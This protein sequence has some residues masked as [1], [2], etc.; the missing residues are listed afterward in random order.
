MGSSISFI[1]LG[2]ILF[3][4]W[5]IFRRLTFIKLKDSNKLEPLWK[6]NKINKEFSEEEKINYAGQCIRNVGVYLL[7]YLISQLG[8]T[9]GLL[10]SGSGFTVLCYALYGIFS[11]IL[12]V[13]IVS[14]IYNAGNLL[15]NYKV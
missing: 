8:V 5:L 6:R 14:E 3:V 1:F 9:I 12:V 10:T 2:I 11:F 13:F 4:L 7:R 15:R